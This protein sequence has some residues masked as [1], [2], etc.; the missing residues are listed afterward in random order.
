MGKVKNGLDRVMVVTSIPI[1]RYDKLKVK[2]LDFGKC[3]DLM[4]VNN[5]SIYQGQRMGASAERKLLGNQY[6]STTAAKEWC[7]KAS[8]YLDYMKQQEKFYIDRVHDLLCEDLYAALP[9]LRPLPKKAA[10]K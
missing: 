6:K 1:H 3:S 9:E 4:K 2:P 5:T 7:T 10:A 8:P